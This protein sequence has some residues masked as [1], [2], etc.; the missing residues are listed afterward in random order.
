M[1][2]G[3]DSSD[4]RYPRRQSLYS[5]SIGQRALYWSGGVLMNVLFTLVAFPI[6][7]RAGVPF[8]APIVGSVEV[9]SAAWEANLR[10][11]D[12]IV[13]IAG[14]PVY[15]FENLSIEV[16]LAGGREVSLVLATPDGGER[17]VL[18]VPQFD[19]NSGR[20]QIGIDGAV[21]DE[22]PTLQIAPGGPGAKAGLQDDDRLLAV[23]GQRLTDGELLPR[24]RPL[25]QPT[26]AALAL[27]VQRGDA[28]LELQLQPTAEP[29]G[30]PRIGVTLQPRRIAGLRP[31]PVVTRLGLQ[32]G[33]VVLALDGQP[34]TRG[35]LQPT[36]A[37]PPNLDLVVRRGGQEVTL[38]TTASPAERVAFAAA[39]A[40]RADLTPVYLLP[41]DDLPVAKAAGLLPG[42]RLL[43]LDGEP[44]ATFDELRDA[45]EAA[46]TRPLQLQVARATR[47]PR[48]SWLAAD[49]ELATDPPVTLAMTP[50]QDQPY[51]TGVTANVRHR[52]EELRAPTIG[53]A[54]ALGASLSVDAVKQLY[55]TLKRMVTG[56]VGAKNLGG[57]IRISQV[58]Y[59]AAQR[60][61]SWFLYLLGMLSLNLAFVNLLPVPILDGGY[62]LFL[63]IEKVKG[64][65]VSARVFGYSQVMG[66]VFVLML[67]VFV[68]Y[69]DILGL[70]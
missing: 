54:I 64:S 43:A 49:G 69:N 45:I 5:K 35:D 51:D 1:A 37:E 58:S 63:L 2:A 61:P 32:R 21:V 44:I 57:I 67:V 65:P 9:G 30:P 13:S 6:A 68:T 31:D 41:S 66:L 12:R 14:K 10:P 36:G 70:L 53:A 55:L 40:L 23:N 4:T 17:T 33:D 34:F 59:Q 26:A 11:G 47:G 15:S 48:A 22:A 39:V 24:I 25:L 16:A 8:Q 20:F 42:D 29:P 50:R 62:L 52:S 3:H 46:G 19:T 18:V 56:D 38:S 7:F 27:Q 60:G 28:T